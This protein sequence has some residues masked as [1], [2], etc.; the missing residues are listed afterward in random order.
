MQIINNTD[1]SAPCSK[2]GRNLAELGSFTYMGT[3]INLATQKD[4]ECQCKN[5]GEHFILCYQYFDK[6]DHINSFVFNGDINDPS[7][8]WQDQ[9]ISEQRESIGAHLKTC[10]I[11]MKK[12]IN[13]ALSDAW[14]ASFI[15]NT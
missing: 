9:L 4:E 11:C 6:N 1:E 8:N 14:L 15:H 12:M 2:C 13:E 3:T 5:C 7:Y 10:E